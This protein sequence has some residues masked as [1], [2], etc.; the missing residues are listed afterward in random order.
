MAGRDQPGWF[1]QNVGQ[2]TAAAAAA[3]RRYLEQ[4]PTV[5]TPGAIRSRAIAS[6]G[7]IGSLFGSS[8]YSA[9][10][11]AT[12]STFAIMFYISLFI[13]VFFLIMMFVHYTMFPVFSFSPNDSGFIPI[14]TVSDKQLAYTKGPAA[15]DLSANFVKLPACTYTLGADVFLSGD[16]MLSQIPRVILYRSSNPV[17]TGGTVDTLLETYPETNLLVWL[18][19]VKNDL[20]VSAITNGTGSTTVIQTSEP[21][22]NVPVRKV[23]RLAVVFTPNFIEVYINGRMEKSMALQNTLVTISDSSYIYSSVKPIQ[24][25]VMLGN[26]SLW[27]RVLTAREINVHESAP[28]KAGA[29]FFRS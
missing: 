5:M 4:N 1:S 12:G 27:P 3:A 18:D 2:R 14:P 25:N 17:I 8:G 13:F 9:Y 6:S 21:V 19:P 23:F 15:F 29:F 20:Y 24:Q 16:F 28:Y 7:W 11:N 22:E 10:Y 26:L